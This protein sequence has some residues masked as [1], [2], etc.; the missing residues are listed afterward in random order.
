MFLDL[1]AWIRA[2]VRSTLF[3]QFS[4][5]IINIQLTS[6]VY[7]CWN[8]VSRLLTLRIM[9]IELPM[10]AI[11][12]YFNFKVIWMVKPD[13]YFEHIIYNDIGCWTFPVYTDITQR[14]GFMCYYLYFLFDFVADPACLGWFW[15]IQNKKIYH[16]KE[17][18]WQ[19]IEEIT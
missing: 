3:V 10:L 19:Y 11:F 15:L 13:F 18:Q 1:E 16:Y 14:A 9:Y 2:V 17:S 4:L 12:R 8:D 6:A 7:L 5:T